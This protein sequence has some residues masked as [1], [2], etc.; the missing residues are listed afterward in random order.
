M[1]ISG[2]ARDGAPLRADAQACREVPGTARRSRPTGRERPAFP[3]G[4]RRRLRL[5]GLPS[6]AGRARAFTVEALADWFGSGTA[7]DADAAAA[8]D[9]VL[10]VAELV[11]NSEAHGGGALELVLDADDTRLRI[12]VSDN[13][14]LLPAPRPSHHPAQPGGHGLFIVERVTDRWGV[15]QHAW[16]KSVWAEVDAKRLTPG[17]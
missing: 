9:V 16:G 15:E 2:G 10:V 5:A 4:A 17:A 3:D 1:T 12:E 6:P 14:A 7:V 11:A 13:G 8:G